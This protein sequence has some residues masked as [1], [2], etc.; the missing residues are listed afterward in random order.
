VKQ[1]ILVSAALHGA[2]FART[3]LRRD[4]A[5][6]R[7][8][9]RPR[10]EVEVCLLHHVL[11]SDFQAHAPA[12]VREIE[13]LL[14]AAPT[15]K[16]TLLCHLLAAARFRGQRSAAAVRCPVELVMGERDAL[17]GSSPQLALCRTLGAECRSL[18]GVGHDVS[19]EAPAA[20]A[21]LV[22]RFL[23]SPQRLG[24]G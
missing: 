5:N 9:L 1:L 10:R 15:P 23:A 19:L 12:R 6:A 21:A 3:P 7:C 17:L 2:S 13:Q 4:L 24:Q 22:N 8:L 18:A 14:R 11:S 16:S 20:L